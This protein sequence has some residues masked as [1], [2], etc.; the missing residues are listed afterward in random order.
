M[1]LF[2]TWIQRQIKLFSIKLTQIHVYTIIYPQLNGF[3]IVQ[4]F[5][6]SF[7]TVEINLVAQISQPKDKNL[8]IVLFENSLCYNGESGASPRSVTVATDIGICS[9]E[10]HVIAIWQNPFFMNNSQS[11]LISRMTLTFCWRIINININKTFASWP[12]Y[13]L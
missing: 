3:L 12:C 8:L 5:N 2:I 7:M 9:M 11:M 6:T 10:S 1:P 4:F 13:V